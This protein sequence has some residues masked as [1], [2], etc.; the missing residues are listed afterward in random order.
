MRSGT[1]RARRDPPRCRGIFF[2]RTFRI[3][4]VEA[5]D[6]LATVFPGEEI[7]H[8]RR[9][10]IADMDAP[11]RRRRE[12][13][14]GRCGMSLRPLGIDR[15]GAAAISRHDHA[16]EK[17]DKRFS[18]AF[19]TVAQGALPKRPRHAQPLRAEVAG[20]ELSRHDGIYR[21]GVF[22]ASVIFLNLSRS[23]SRLAL[24]APRR[25]AAAWAAAENR[26]RQSASCA[27]SA[28]WRL[29]PNR[30]WLDLRS[31]PSRL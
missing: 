6:E 23:P 8:Q 19:K 17:L 11:G 9:S 4:V 12:T 28:D 7:I 16:L 15:A 13:H 31:R 10:R 26:P 3:G 18:R 14:D 30:P 1:R 24:P 29:F 22:C 5:Q 27:R 21:R 20:L 2:C 25:R